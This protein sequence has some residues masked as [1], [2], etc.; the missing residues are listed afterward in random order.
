MMDWLLRKF[1]TY[2]APE[3][4]LVTQD[5][6]NVGNQSS[7]ATLFRR[8]PVRNAIIL[9]LKDKGPPQVP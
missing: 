7:I 4:T 9:A 3:Y 5:R 1:E 6:C 2:Y 8:C